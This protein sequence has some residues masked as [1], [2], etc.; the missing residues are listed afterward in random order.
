MKAPT[1]DQILELLAPYITD[2]KRDRIEAALL[3]RTYYVTIALEDIYQSHNASAV[4]RSCDCFGIQQINIIENRNQYQVNPDVAL[5]ASKWVDLIKYNNPDIDN[6]QTCLDS[7]RKKGYRILAT[8]PDQDAKD[9][10]TIDINQRMAFFFG[11]ELEGL[12]KSLLNKADER[13]RIPM[14]GFTKSFNISVS[15]ALIMH[16]ITS[17]LHAENHISWQVTPEEKMDLRLKWYR[18][19]IKKSA[20]LEKAFLEQ[21]EKKG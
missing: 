14:Y 12:S 1:K 3:H 16:S 8:T 5:G 4:L 9:I 13:V 18:R 6:S 11:T 2:H 7:L 15:A 10:S 21:I 19:I 17:R 20:L